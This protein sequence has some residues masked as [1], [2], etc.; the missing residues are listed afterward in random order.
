MQIWR[1]LLPAL[2]G[3]GLFNVLHIPVP[4][5]LGPLA[6][7]AVSNSVLGPA[8][9]LRWPLPMRNGGLIVLGYMMGISFTI[10]TARQ[11][12][13]QFP[14]MLTSTIVLILFSLLLAYVVSRQTGINLPTSLLGNIP[15]G[16]TQMVVLCDE[17]AGTDVSLVT[18]LQTFRFLA[19]III[20][21]FLAY[22]TAAGIGPIVPVDTTPA[23]VVC[24]A[25]WWQLAAVSAAVL[26]STWL[27][28][29]RELPTPYLLGPLVGATLAV[30]AGLPGLPLPRPLMYAAQVCVG[31][32]MGS[33]IDLTGLLRQKRT[34]LPYIVASGVCIVA[35]SLTLAYFLAY[36]HSI[37]TGTAF[38]STAPGGL[39]EMGATALTLNVDI[40]LVAAY[41]MFRLLFILFV[42][43]PVLKYW[44]ARVYC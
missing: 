10:D 13:A 5:M 3:G 35:F 37:P 12:L 18:L 40:S 19:A 16:L 43:P 29:R 25:A 36:F 31:T 4:W 7:V 22:H 24:Q 27:A 44:M 32:Y 30:L 33:T 15:G 1:T 38:L 39:A 6:A 26:L 21:P 42:V 9:R 2:A 8:R 14:F 17:V 34:F 23:P 20:V 41:Q 28:V 11:I